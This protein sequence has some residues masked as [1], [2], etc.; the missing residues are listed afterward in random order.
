MVLVKQ[1]PR[2]F[3]PILHPAD[4]DIFNMMLWQHRNCSRIII[5]SQVRALAI[6]D[7]MILNW[8]QICT[9]DNILCPI[10]FVHSIKVRF[11]ALW[12]YM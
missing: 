12:N 2:F 10:N 3:L 1:K 4:I 9:Y 11:K 8:V 6:G 7:G 5:L